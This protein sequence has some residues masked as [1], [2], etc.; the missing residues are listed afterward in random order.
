MAVHAHFGF[1]GGETP[2]IVH[3]MTNTGVTI[4][5]IGEMIFGRTIPSN[6]PF[7]TEGVV[8]FDTPFGRVCINL[9]IADLKANEAQ[10]RATTLQDALQE[11]LSR[12]RIKGICFRVCIPIGC[13]E[14]CP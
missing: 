13:F 2:P 14:V 12:P 3:P 7:D 5:D 10:A 8:C 1:R 4:W 6:P 11:I 9:K